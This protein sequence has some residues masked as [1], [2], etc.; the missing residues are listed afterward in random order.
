MGKHFIII[1][2]N[3][4]I[5]LLILFSSLIILVIN[6]VKHNSEIYK[7][8][9]K[10]QKYINFYFN[11]RIKTPIKIAIFIYK[12]TGGGMQRETVLFLEY[13]HNLKIFDL[14]LFTLNI[15]EKEDFLVPINI[16]RV[17]IENEKI[18]NLIRKTKKK[19]IELVIYQYP[20][21]YDIN[22]L[23]R[24]KKVKIIFYQHSSLFFW[25]YYNTFYLRTIYKEYINS[26][27]IVSLIPLENDYIFRSWGINS[28]L[29]SNYITFDYKNVKPSDLSSKTILMIG[30]GYD[31]YKRFYLGI[32]AMEYI[33]K[34]IPESKI[35]IISHLN[36][37]EYLQ[38][39]IKNINLNNNILFVGFSS[40]PEI[41]FKNASLHILPTISESFS[42][43]LCET[44]IYGIPSILLGLDYITLSKGGTIII[45]DDSIESLAKESI[46]ILKN[47]PYRKK[48]GKEARL[49]IKKLNNNSLRKRWIKLL[50]SIYNGDIY[51]QN[52]KNKDKKLPKLEAL[53]ILENQINLL[54]KRNQKYQNFTVNNFINFTILLNM[55]T[56]ISQNLYFYL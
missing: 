38:D 28:I 22:F 25:F 46:K 52:L 35:K 19:K 6:L 33:I 49:S 14:Y 3:K 23:N 27:Y 39:L 10:T 51:Y 42:L 48:L 44:K 34:E 31:K 7:N 17:F 11:N 45:Y 29:M 15:Y 30:R 9:L 56:N 47:K 2:L 53:N 26:K 20:K 37:T 50:L 4:I 21:Q 43:A 13:L 12:L 40:K 1:N 36:Y 24:L 55:N 5:V 41:Y 16:K 8:Y 18:I 32:L 54:K